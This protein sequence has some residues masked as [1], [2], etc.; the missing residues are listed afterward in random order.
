MSENGAVRRGLPGVLTLLVLLVLLGFLWENRS[1]VAASYSLRPELFLAVAGLTLLGLFVRGV[2]NRLH[3]SG[4]GVDAS[5]A[6]WFRLVAVTSFTNYLPLSAGLVAKAVFLK[7]VHALPFAHFAVG[8]TTLLVLIVATNGLVGLVLLGIRFPEEL[9]GVVGLGF[10]LMLASGGLLVLPPRMRELLSSRWFP[11]A[12][13]VGS[14]ARRRWAVVSLCQVGML[15]AAAFALK[16]CFA[17]GASSVD[18][19]ACLLFTAAAVVTRFVTIVPGALGIREFLI[20]GLA[21]LTGFD[22]RDAVVASTLARLAEILVVFVVGGVFTWRLSG[23]L[24]AS[25]EGAQ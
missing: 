8:Q 18:F 13:D 11:L 9:F 4:L 12:T 7:R 15:C 24:A 6:A 20:G 1:Y 10:A 23:E 5:T 14:A 25:Y 21:V 17:M 3:F 16:L 19:G 22:L 2:A